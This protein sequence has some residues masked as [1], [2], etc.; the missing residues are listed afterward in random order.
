M[1]FQ[2]AGKNHAAAGVYGA[3]RNELL[4]PHNYKS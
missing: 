4:K 1:K 3:Q 2:K